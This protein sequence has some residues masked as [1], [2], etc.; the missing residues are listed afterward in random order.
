MCGKMALFAYILKIAKN[1][2][3]LRL[4]MRAKETLNRHQ[5]FPLISNT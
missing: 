5:F 1:D 4:L 3:F 2:P